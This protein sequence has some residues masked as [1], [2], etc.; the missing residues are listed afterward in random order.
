[1]TLT[2][3]FCCGLVAGLMQ[4]HSQCV[5]ALAPG[6]HT[7]EVNVNGESRDYLV[8]VPP[9]YHAENP[10]PMVLALHGGGGNMHIQANERF[11]H[12]ISAADKYGYVVLF[13]NGYSRL[14]GG[15]F[16]TWNAGSCCGAAVKQRIDDVA[17]IRSM[18]SDM[19][20]RANIDPKRIFVEGM[21]NGGMMSYRLACELSGTI[22]AIAA[23]A[24]TDNTANCQPSSPV[25]ILHIHAL[26]DDHVPF[27]GGVGQKS[28]ADVSFNSV[29]ATIQRWVQLNRAQPTPKRILEVPGAYCDQYNG[30]LAPIQL[31]VTETGGHSWP[32]GSKPFGGTAGSTAISAN[33]IIWQ[34]FNAN[35]RR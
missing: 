33:D 11:Y 22:S 32:G 19:Q 5:A 1:M 28:M 17:V 24:G 12:Q 23:V 34:F 26:D 25:A 9:Q 2:R 30:G 14:P 8:H 15:K 3:L 6:D 13:P 27:Q 16:A 4:F 35:G 29:P 18:I 31:C 20:Q 21:S 7:F 10:I